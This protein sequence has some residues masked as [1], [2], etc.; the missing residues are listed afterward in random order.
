MC[1]TEMKTTIQK[2][3]LTIDI[4]RHLNGKNILMFTRNQNKNQNI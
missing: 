2:Q 4:N 1:W 3:I